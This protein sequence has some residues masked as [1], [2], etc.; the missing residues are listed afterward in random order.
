MSSKIFPHI[1]SSLF[2]RY[3]VSYLFANLFFL[4]LCGGPAARSQASS[5]RVVPRLIT[6]PVDVMS[7]TTVAKEASVYDLLL[8]FE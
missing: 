5:D 7:R 1:G 2:P 3:F 4:G 8:F 6:S